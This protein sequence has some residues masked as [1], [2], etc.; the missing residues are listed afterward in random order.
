[1]ATQLAPSEQIA[2]STVR[3]EV[4]LA[5]GRCGTG[6]GFF[7]R[8]ANEQ[9]R[10]VPA[11]VTNKHVVE[12]AVRGRFHLSTADAEGNPIYS[13]HEVFSFDGFQRYWVPH[14]DSEIDLCAM[15]IAPILETARQS[16]KR[17]FYVPLDMTLIPSTND[18]GELT[19]M[20]DILMAGYPN[21]IWDEKNNMPVLRRGV[22]ATHPDLDW[23]GKPEFLIDAAC[24]P[25]SSGSPV[26]LFNV[27]GY[28]KKSGGMAIG[29][30]IKLLG[31]LYAGPQHTVEGE[32]RIVKVPT[33]DRPV[34]VST[35]PNNLGIVV[36]ARKLDAFDDFFR[37]KLQ[38]EAKP[39]NG[40]QATPESGRA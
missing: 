6:T 39:N 38:A 23:N 28:A 12:G 40:V 17:L 35:I 16:G 10:H 3:I 37:S 34:S 7:F 24:F 5:D 27:G 2:H 31:V 30:R 11:I 20:E 15:P 18:L 13:T 26:F 25:G 22:T 4:E 36:K 33:L 14:P 29:T 8:F 9:D 32:I 21:G 1:M 19:A